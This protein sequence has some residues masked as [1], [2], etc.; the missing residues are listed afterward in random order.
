M[1]SSNF[2]LASLRGLLGLY[3]SVGQT[4]IIVQVSDLLIFRWQHTAIII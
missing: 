2:T 4:A 1:F 3:S